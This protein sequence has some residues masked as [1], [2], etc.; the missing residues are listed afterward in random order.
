MTQ[1]QGARWEDII[2]EKPN[3]LNLFKNQELESPNTTEML[4]IEGFL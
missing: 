2:G 4:R 1:Q 3:D